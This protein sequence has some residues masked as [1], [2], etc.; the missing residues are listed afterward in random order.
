MFDSDEDD[1]Q[2]L[3]KIPTDVLNP[4]GEVGKKQRIKILR[5]NSMVDN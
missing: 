2:V 1:A 3:R 5:K 4:E